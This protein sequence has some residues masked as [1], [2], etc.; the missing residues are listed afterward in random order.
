MS[1]RHHAQPG[2][3][4]LWGVYELEAQAVA[5]CSR[6]APE[7]APVNIPVAEVMPIFKAAPTVIVFRSPGTT[8]GPT[9]RVCTRARGAAVIKFQAVSRPCDVQKRPDATGPNE[10]KPAGQKGFEPIFMQAVTGSPHMCVMKRLPLTANLKS[11]GVSAA[12]FW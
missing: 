7:P 10:K 3:L 5:A 8:N 12:H 4:S 9:S 6:P 11:G 1:K 2:Q